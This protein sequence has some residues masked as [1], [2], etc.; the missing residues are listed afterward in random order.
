M[1]GTKL[2]HLAKRS[3]ISMRWSTSKNENSKK[4]PLDDITTRIQNTNV[5]KTNTT[6]ESKHFSDVPNYTIV[7]TECLS[8]L[9][10]NHLC[11]ICHTASPIFCFGQRN[12]FAYKM[13]VVCVNCDQTQSEI[14]SSKQLVDTK[15]HHIS[16]AGKNKFFNAP[17]DV[18]MRIVQGILSLGLGYSALKKFC[19]HMNLSI[20]S[21]KAFNSYK[22]K[23]L[24]GHLVGSNQLLLDVRKNVREAY[25]SK[26]DKVIADI[27][28]S[29]VKSW[30]SIGCT[31]NIGVGCVIDL[32]TGF[33]ID[34]EEVS[35]RATHV[36]SSGAMEVNTAVKLWERSEI[37]GFRYTTLL[38]DGDSKY[39]LEIKEWN[40]YGSDVEAMKTAIYATLFHCMFTNQKPHPKKYPSGIDSWCFY[41]SSLARGKK[42]GFHKDWVKTPI[43]EEY[44][45]KILPIY[46]RLV[47]SELLSSEYDFAASKA[48]DHDVVCDD[49]ENNSANPQ[50]LVV[51]SQI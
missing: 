19:I 43:N 33:V 51:E 36:G 37:I 27:G 38:S 50:T 7:D 6:G 17:F 15:L 13:N 12:E 23:V 32:L 4:Q 30:L 20:M 5:L 11:N 24:K 49:T 44:L 22:A 28:V 10:T 26:N 41:Q 47:S 42:P 21:S 34:Y 29:Y 39:F 14:C 8:N 45:P 16:N 9:F 25:G 46:Q 31:S 2:S 48:T 18:N 3:N 40:V 1:P 35:E